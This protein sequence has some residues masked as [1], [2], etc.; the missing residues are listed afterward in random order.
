MAVMGLAARSGGGGGVFGALTTPMDTPRRA[1][2]RRVPTTTE[3]QF[4]AF[5][6]RFGKEFVAQ[7]ER[8]DDR[9]RLRKQEAKAE[10]AP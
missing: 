9:R 1:P 4:L 7:R 3:P 10:G 6:S 5:D 2:M 8:S